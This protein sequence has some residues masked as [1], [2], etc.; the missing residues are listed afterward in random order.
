MY[1]P[2]LWLFSGRRPGQPISPSTVAAIYYNARDKAGIK[3]GKGIHTMRH[4][5]EFQ[6]MPSNDCKHGG[7]LTV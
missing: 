6:I 5:A 7:S 3:K 2:S 1:H 4:Y